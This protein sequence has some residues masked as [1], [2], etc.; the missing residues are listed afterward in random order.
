M[1]G[2]ETLSS[3]YREQ[4]KEYIQVYPASNNDKERGC[5]D[6]AP[7]KDGRNLRD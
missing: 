1:P 2:D 4:H 3:G 7:D 6:E 5:F